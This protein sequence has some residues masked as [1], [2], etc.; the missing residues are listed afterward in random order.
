MFCSRLQPA[1]AY[2]S[3]CRE[4][5]LFICD[6]KKCI[7]QIGDD[8][9]TSDDDESDLDEDCLMTCDTSEDSMA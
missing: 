2:S 3:V 8:D 1:V 4:N 9:V 7:S 5:Y 6:C